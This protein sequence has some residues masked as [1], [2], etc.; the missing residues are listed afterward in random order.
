[1]AWSSAFPKTCNRFSLRPNVYINSIQQSAVS[2]QQSAFSILQSA[3]SIQHSAPT[4]AP[5]SF[6]PKLS[7][8][9]LW[10]LYL[11]YLILGLKESLRP[12]L[13]HFH[14]FASISFFF[15]FLFFLF[16]FFFLLPSSHF[17]SFNSVN[18]AGYNWG[19]W[20]EAI[21]LW[22]SLTKDD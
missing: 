4:V 3:L 17:L 2:I 5:T 7:C 6:L 8:F 9:V 22:M 11:S 20:Q 1:M 18:A 12:L 14:D 10:V 16:S 15:L 19:K 13:F 21:W